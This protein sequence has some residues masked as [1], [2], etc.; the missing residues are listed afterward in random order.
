MK[1]VREIERS[2][3]VSAPALRMLKPSMIAAAVACVCGNAW[4]V[5]GGA[6]VAGQGTIASQGATTT[7]SQ[8]SDRMVVNWK[9]FDIAQGETVNFNQPGASSAVLNRVVSSTRPTEILGALNANGR[10]FVV[11]QAGV[12]FGKTATVNTDSLVVSTMDIDTQQF[13]DGGRAAGNDRLLDLKSGDGD[14]LVSN[15]GKLN[16]NT[17]VVLLGGQVVNTGE[18]RANGNVTLG[19]ADSATLGIKNSM[20]SVGLSAPELN[21]LARNDGLIVS[22]GGDVRL[23]AMGTGD[24]LRTVVAN[25]GTLEAHT[26]KVGTGG[27]IVLG[28]LADGQISV[29]GTLT[30]DKTID[31]E[32][33]PQ[34]QGAKGGAVIVVQGASLKGSDVTLNAAGDTM[35]S[36]GTYTADRLTLAG[37]NVTINRALDSGN[38]SVYGRAGVQQNANINAKG[39]VNLS[40]DNITQADGV[41]TSGQAI[42][43]NGSPDK[44]AVRTATLQGGDVRVSGKSV[45][46][47]GDATGDQL[48]QINGSSITAAKQLKST[49]GTVAVNALGGTLVTNGAV[50]GNSVQLTGSNVTVNAAVNATRDVVLGGGDG[51]VIQNA[52]VTS[53]AGNVNIAATNLDQAT[54]V[55]TTAASGVNIRGTQAGYYPMGNSP[56]APGNIRTQTIKAGN[57]SISAAGSNV[58]LAGDI[59]AD[60][61][62]NV[63]AGNGSV[64]AQK[65]LA[66]TY[67]PISI[68]ANTIAANGAVKSGNVVQFQANNSIDVNAPITASADV[69]LDARM[70]KLTQKAD[71]VSTNGNVALSGGTIDQ[72]SD[73]NTKAANQVRVSANVTQSG[74]TMSGGTAKIANVAAHDVLINGQN[75]SLNG[76][77]TADGSIEASTAM[78]GGVINQSG[79]LTSR[80]GMVNMRSDTI[81]QTSSSMTNGGNGVTLQASKIASGNI[82]SDRAITLSGSDVTLGGKLSAPQVNVPANA[83]N[84]AG[85]I[86]ITQAGGGQNGS[87]SSGGQS[88]GQS[89]GQSGQPAQGG[90]VIDQYGRVVGLAVDQQGRTIDQDGLSINQYGQLFNKN[91]QLI[92]QIVAQSQGGPQQYLLFIGPVP[93][94]GSANASNGSSTAQT[95]AMTPS[96]M[97]Y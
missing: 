91:G 82:T 56:V 9:N 12:M 19:A 53:T 18:I 95:V 43:I 32:T 88:G 1:N 52:N 55:V 87:Q 71:I 70:G 86:V 67:G 49:N 50:S 27:N 89:S 62:I 66:S 68:N 39:A 34:L 10:V 48:L 23:S 36:A 8:T 93:Q 11:N 73:V 29:D 28:S 81:Q 6:V 84:T 92:G 2:N 30:A 59:T 77:I 13:M 54:G 14:A 38:I 47:A 78:P 83:K 17:Q 24:A 60:G 51:S 37:D 25:T 76:T 61:G 42:T 4:A 57:V 90:V 58:T 26:A 44:G 72:A 97:R 85:N 74:P 46:L 96:G 7:V 3:P 22:Q 63:D 41:L 5:Q 33:M 79:S 35:T 40:A 16:A 20:F 15:D 45:T 75:I 21:A 65:M 94:G 31:I 80:N 64:I 69:M